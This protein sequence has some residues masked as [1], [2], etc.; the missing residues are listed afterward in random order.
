MARILAVLAPV[1]LAGA[2]LLLT[3]DR[4]GSDWRLF[5]G[6]WRTRDA[7]VAAGLVV[8][9]GGAACALVSR[10]A[11]RGYA[12]ILFLAGASL[13]LLEVVGFLGLVSY[14]P[15]F[16]NLRDLPTNDLGAR[17]APHLDVRGETFQDTATAWGLAHEPIPFHYR[18][19]R[20]GFRNP[21]DPGRADVY[22]LGDSIVV[23]GLVPFEQTLTARL[24]RETGLSLMNVALV[25]IGPQEE[26]ALFRD[27]DLPVRGGVVLQLLF[28]GNDLRDS[29]RLRQA[30]ERTVLLATRARS[31]SQNVVLAVQRRTQPVVGL[32][33]RRTCEID[34]QVYTFRWTDGA[35]RGL[36]GEQAIVLRA[37]EEFRDE[38]EAA[39]GRFGV[40]FVPAK[41]RVLG[42]VCARWPAE[43]DL[44]DVIDAN[45][46]RQT[47][48]TW[49]REHGVPLVDLTDPLRASARDG[50]IPWFWGDT[51][52]N[53]IG[54]AV[55]ARAL[56]SS[57]LLAAMR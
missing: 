39:G 20:Y 40:V 54:H 5:F 19:D 45:P 6:L 9:A 35:F 3:A 14:A 16:G 18:T 10:R 23:A 7:L 13:V 48:Q 46:L 36:E 21:S 12:Y 50:G 32:A 37:V 47:V 11:A 31:F 34:G 55:A 49:S 44:R 53:E 4:D 2:W 38:I 25:G 51:H 15:R 43:S 42:P 30:E 52:W 41:L 33:R 29:A 28:E 56:A 26:H 17:R 57:P 8:L 1:T 24:E 22:L 27:A